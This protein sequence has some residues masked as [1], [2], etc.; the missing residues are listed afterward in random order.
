LP[1]SDHP[2]CSIEALSCSIEAF[3]F[4]LE[5]VPLQMCKGVELCKGLKL[6]DSVYDSWNGNGDGIVFADNDLDL[7]PQIQPLFIDTRSM[8]NVSTDTESVEDVNNNFVTLAN[9]LRTDLRKVK[10]ICRMDPLVMS[11]IFPSNCLDMQRKLKNSRGPLE[12]SEQ[13]RIVY[14]KNK[15]ETNRNLPEWLEQPVNFSDQACIKNSNLKFS[16]STPWGVNK[17]KEA[18]HIVEPEKL[19][20]IPSLYAF[21]AQYT[22]NLSTMLEDQSKGMES[23]PDSDQSSESDLD[24]S[25]EID[26]D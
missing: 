20:S 11:N 14:S 7:V 8:K 4:E 6:K 21:S 26:V 12:S 3:D 17:N 22:P 5:E 24:Q 23:E 15:M 1:N 2:S 19:V 10:Q 9:Q 25:S 16:C 13:R 18:P